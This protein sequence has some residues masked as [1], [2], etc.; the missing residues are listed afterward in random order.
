MNDN[1]SIKVAVPLLL[2]STL[3]IAV[4]CLALRRRHKRNFWGGKSLRVSPA[5]F[6]ESTAAFSVNLVQVSKVHVFI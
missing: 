1:I 6:D 5:R 4:A 2:S 3:A